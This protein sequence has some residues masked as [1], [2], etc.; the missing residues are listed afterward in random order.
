MQI[1]KISKGNIKPIMWNDIAFVLLYHIPNKYP[2]SL[3][4]I[5]Y[6]DVSYSSDKLSVLDDGRA[7]QVCG[8]EGTTLFT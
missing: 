1:L 8:Q 6:R 4:R 5:V 3:S 2:I 7:A